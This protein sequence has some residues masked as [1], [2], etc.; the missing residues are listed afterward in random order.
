MVT[1]GGMYVFQ[2]FDFYGASGVCLLTIAFFES[3]TIAWFYG[4]SRFGENTREMLGFRIPMWFD[5]CWK[6]LTPII[7]MFVLLLSVFLLEPVK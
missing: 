6:Y 7:T 3:I 4:A 2:L 1:K 5:I